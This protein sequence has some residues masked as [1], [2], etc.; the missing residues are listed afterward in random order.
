[1]NPPAAI[2]IIDMQK[3]SFTPKTPRY[4]AVS[5]VERINEIAHQFRL[6]NWPVIHIQHDGSGSG[7][8]EKGAWDWEVLDELHIADSDLQIDK[9][10]NDVFYQSSLLP[11]LKKIRVRNLYISG[12]ATDFYV[13]SSI[14]SALSK[15][16]HITVISD[17]HTTGERPQLIA[18]QVIDHYNWVWQNM[19]PTQGFIKVMSKIEILQDLEKS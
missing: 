11:E 10:A 7:A 3:G 13:E 17:G 12:C 5:T 4:D 18:K 19:L 9:T 2:L 16:F 6:L 15:D 8:F 1:M 14:Q